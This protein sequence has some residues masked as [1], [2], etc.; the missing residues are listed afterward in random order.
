[1]KKLLLIASI[2]LLK[3]VFIAQDTITTVPTFIDNNGSSAI[4][5]EV[6][7]N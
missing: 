2:I 1:M 4:S 3:F 7:A 5:F 6:F